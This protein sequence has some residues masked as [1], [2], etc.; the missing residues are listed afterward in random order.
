M[1]IVRHVLIEFAV[2]G[3]RIGASARTFVINRNHHRRGG[4][5][6]STIVGRWNDMIIWW[7]SR[8]LNTSTV[9]GAKH[10]WYANRVTMFGFYNRNIYNII[11]TKPLHNKVS[12]NKICFIHLKLRKCFLNFFNAVSLFR[13][14]E[15][16]KYG[17]NLVQFYI[18][19]DTYYWETQRR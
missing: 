1:G 18:F 14:L 19:G 17:Y 10:W 3:H 2:K 13:K 15:S 16:L 4:W 9:S 5:S 8:V 6:C 12:L 11:T 7:R